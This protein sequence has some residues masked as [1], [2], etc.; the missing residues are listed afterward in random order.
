MMTLFKINY[1]ELNVYRLP[2]DKSS[3][4]DLDELKTHKFKNAFIKNT[5][6]C[7]TGCRH[8]GRSRRGRVRRKIGDRSLQQTAVIT[9]GRG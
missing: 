9:K 4:I 5:N 8:L 3:S 6:L 7:Y 1:F 2:Q